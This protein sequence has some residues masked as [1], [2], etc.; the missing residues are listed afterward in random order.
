MSN[1]FWM[2]APAWTNENI[3]SVCG[4]FVLIQLK[5]STVAG[6]LHRSVI[7][8]ASSSRFPSE[9]EVSKLPML[10]VTSFVSFIKR[11]FLKLSQSELF[12]SFLQAVREL[13][14]PV[15]IIASRKYR[16]N[17][18]YQMTSQCKKTLLTI[19][20]RSWTT[21]YLFKALGL[22][23]GVFELLSPD[24]CFIHQSTFFLG[25]HHYAIS[26]LY[27][28]RSADI[29]GHCRSLCVKLKFILFETV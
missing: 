3:I 18:F 22:K 7:L 9:Y 13:I 23:R 20:D 14:S 8:L 25:K 19:G 27:I 28:G 21:L 16:I 12:N 15:I 29:R 11:P 2:V 10:L 6:M 17:R 4:G 1:L 26:I 24:W 5:Q